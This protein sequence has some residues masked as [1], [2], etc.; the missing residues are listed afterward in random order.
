[1]YTDNNG[2]PHVDKKQN[3]V[4]EEVQTSRQHVILVFYRKFDTCDKYDYIFDVCCNKLH[5]F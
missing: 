5:G 1:M 3:Y 4:L 2:V